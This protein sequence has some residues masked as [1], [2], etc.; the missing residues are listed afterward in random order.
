[1]VIP[2]GKNIAH[3]FFSILDSWAMMM[4]ITFL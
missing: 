4:A 3:G 2:F 1:M